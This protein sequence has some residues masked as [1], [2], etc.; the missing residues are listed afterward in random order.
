MEQYTTDPNGWLS[1]EGKDEDV[2]EIKVVRLR[3]EDANA[4]NMIDDMVEDMTYLAQ[5]TFMTNGVYMMGAE[6]K[7]PP[8]EAKI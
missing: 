1:S 4:V 7:Y 8:M 5:H 6:Y 3:F 2:D